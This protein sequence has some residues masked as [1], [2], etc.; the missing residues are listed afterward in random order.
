M[1]RVNYF[2]QVALPRSSHPTKV[3]FL[4]STSISLA[5]A[6]YAKMVTSLSSLR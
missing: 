3:N 4:V 1:V 5:E 6:I 2:W